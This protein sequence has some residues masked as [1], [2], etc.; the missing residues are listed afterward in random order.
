[1][2]RQYVN[3]TQFC[4]QDPGDSAEKAVTSNHRLENLPTFTDSQKS[5]SEHRRE[6]ALFSRLPIFSLRQFLIPGPSLNLKK[7]ERTAASS[8]CVRPIPRVRTIRWPGQLLW[9]LFGGDPSEDHS[10]FIFLPGQ[11]GAEIGVVLDVAEGY[12][13]L[14]GSAPQGKRERE[15]DCVIESPFRRQEED[16]ISKT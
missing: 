12:A 5:G 9:H 16:L 8:R 11:Q 15:L 10:R 7:R 4:A 14:V 3:L 6:D 1:V 2:S 13:V